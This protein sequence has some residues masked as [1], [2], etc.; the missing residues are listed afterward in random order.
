MSGGLL[1]RG[2]VL[3]EPATRTVLY[4]SGSR[5]DWLYLSEVHGYTRACVN[6]T[7]KPTWND[8]LEDLGNPGEIGPCGWMAL[9]D[10]VLAATDHAGRVEA[11]RTACARSC[12]YGP[13]D[14]MPP[15]A[16]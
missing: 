7:V 14:P 3:F 5:G 4:V 11:V 13:A 10:G 6:P 15:P 1:Q 16:A 12:H 2:H 8:G 9:R